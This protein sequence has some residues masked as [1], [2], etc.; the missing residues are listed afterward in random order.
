MGDIDCAQDAYL[1]QYLRVGAM[2]S[3]IDEP[4]VVLP[5]SM[6]YVVREVRVCRCTTITLT[7][8]HSH[9]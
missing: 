7:T 6:D 3:V 4:E 8:D 2:L 1:L 5:E 9:P